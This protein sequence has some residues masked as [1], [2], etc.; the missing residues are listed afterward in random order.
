MSSLLVF[1]R[2]IIYSPGSKNLKTLRA[3]KN[4]RVVSQM[5]V[6]IL[7]HEVLFYLQSAR[8]QWK[9]WAEVCLIS[10]T[11]KHF[12]LCLVYTILHSITYLASHL[13]FEI[14]YGLVHL[15]YFLPIRNYS[16]L[17]YYSLVFHLAPLLYCKFF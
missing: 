5:C 4:L 10:T 14:K 3:L 11:H 16:W 12:L 2:D 13:H 15:R 8:S 7:S 9:K 6:P 17:P 1:L